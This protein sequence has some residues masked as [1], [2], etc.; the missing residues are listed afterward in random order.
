LEADA[1][2]PRRC[3]VERGSVADP[4]DD[5]LRVFDHESAT[6]RTIDFAE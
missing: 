3:E 5:V 1:F 4:A 2:E 6:D